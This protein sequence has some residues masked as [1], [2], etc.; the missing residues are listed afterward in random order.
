MIIDP[1]LYEYANRLEDAGFTIYEPIGSG[2]FFRYSRVVHGQ[3]CFGYVQRT[4]GSTGYAYQHLMPIKPSIENGSSMTVAG[5][6][7]ALTI[8]SA[9]RV[10]RPVNRND[11]VGPQGNWADP[12]WDRLYAKR[13][14]TFVPEGATGADS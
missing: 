12:A 2:N 9:V 5:V 13:N 11:V 6:P 14:A 10:A 3:E 7:N 1:A 4:W 8:E